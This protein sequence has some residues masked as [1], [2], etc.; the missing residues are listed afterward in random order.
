MLWHFDM[1]CS[2]EQ[3]KLKEYHFEYAV[4]THLFDS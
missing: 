1:H 3:H 4:E 2:R